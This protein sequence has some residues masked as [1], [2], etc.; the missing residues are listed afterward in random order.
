MLFFST[1]GSFLGSVFS[2]LVLMNT[3]GVRT[4][5]ILTLA[6]LASLLPLLNH[7]R[8]YLPL[9]AGAAILV[10]AGV[11]NSSFFYDR[12]GIVSDNAYNTTAVTLRADGSRILDIN[13][14]T[15]SGLTKDGKLFFEYAQ[16]IDTHFI[17][18]LALDPGDPYDIL[19]I[20]AG[21]FT[22]GRED[23]HNRYT[24]VDIDPALK[25]V[26]EQ[27]FLKQELTPNKR[28]VPASARAFLARE[29]A[30]YDL[31]IVDTF[32]NMYSVPMETTTQEFL[33][34]AKARLNR[35]GILIVNMIASPDFADTFSIRYDHTFASVFP[36]HTRQVLGDFN[37]WVMGTPPHNQ[38][39]VLYIY[40]HREGIDDAVTYTDD[41]NTYSMDR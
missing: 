33:L 22:I 27:H 28:F 10:L 5:V 9:F 12:L 35:H 29:Q 13:R 20:G 17:R 40:Y 39:N 34:A 1:A 41:R 26:S 15:S 30:M 14:S 23:T 21:G 25:R 2:T 6:L 32:T 3:I 16:Y 24:Y 38:R 4:T 11:A 18:P 31:I 37:P 7:R 8:Q 19:M 36:R